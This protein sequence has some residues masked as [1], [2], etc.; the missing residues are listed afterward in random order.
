M[1]DDLTELWG[2]PDAHAILGRRDISA[3]YRLLNSRGVS[4]S[5]IA[6]RTGQNQSEVHDIM[7]GRKVLSYAL[8]ERIAE[9]LSIPRGLMGLPYAGTDRQPPSEEDEDVKRR[10]FMTLVSSLALGGTV[11]DEQR[12]MFAP[13]TDYEP[14]PLTTMV[15]PSDVQALTALVDAFRATDRRH[16]GYGQYRA[17]LSAVEYG[18]SLDAAEADERTR[19]AIF[20]GLAYCHSAAGW[21][22]TEEGHT[23]T[24]RAHYGRGLSFAG[25][26]RDA[27]MRARLLYCAG[28]TELHFGDPA[29]ATK[30][31]QLGTV[32]VD[33]SPLMMSILCANAAWS[34][35][36]AGFSEYAAR[37]INEARSHHADVDFSRDTPTFRWFRAPD[38]AAVTG[39][40]HIAR[41]DYEAA[42]ADLDVA[43]RGRRPWEHRSLAFETANLA[44]V[45]LALGDPDQA[46]TVGQQTIGHA[47]HVRSARLAG[48]LAPLIKESAK[49]QGSDVRQ[50]GKELQQSIPAL[51]VQA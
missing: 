36:K 43:V 38:L 33:R 32:G 22:A 50:L 4:Q 41:G 16:G 20:S 45:H 26:A 15:R 28:R 5:R 39:A 14:E 1:I 37:Q 31:F 18:E 34:S 42:F 11:S 51:S 49:R 21:F 27:M 9:G 8:L 13:A 25:K 40:G 3:L 6:M 23:E 19:R 35:A 17:A 10:A 30:L 2:H 12:Q 47:E 48:R 24:A 29:A 7:R 46:V 44:R